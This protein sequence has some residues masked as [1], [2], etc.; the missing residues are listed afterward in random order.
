MKES[1]ITAMPLR[2]AIILS[3]KYLTVCQCKIMSLPAILM[4]FKYVGS[5]EF[6]IGCLVNLQKNRKLWVLKVANTLKCT[7]IFTIIILPSII[8]ICSSN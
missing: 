1:T 7:D 3:A 6:G 8:I 4:I 2:C 5:Q